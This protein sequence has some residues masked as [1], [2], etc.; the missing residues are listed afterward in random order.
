[1][2]VKKMICNRKFNCAHIANIILAKVYAILKKKVRK[3]RKCS[4]GLLLLEEKKMILCSL[5][6]VNKISET[7][8]LIDR[9]FLNSSKSVIFLVHQKLE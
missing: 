2:Y 7:V 5:C 3:G 6:G 4:D 1:M 8:I 9:C